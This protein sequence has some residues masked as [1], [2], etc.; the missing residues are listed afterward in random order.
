M[1]KKICFVILVFLP[2]FLWGQE[3]V[4]KIEIQGNDRVTKET[5]LYYLSSRE[6][7]YFSR[8]IIRDDF[9]VLWS[10]GF[11]IGRQPGC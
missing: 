1:R 4:E 10:T 6:G 7:D 3:K 8:E 5:I 11:F 2:L 9:R